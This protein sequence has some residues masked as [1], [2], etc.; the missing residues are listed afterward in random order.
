MPGVE[1]IYDRH[2]YGPEKADA[3]NRLAAE[4]GKIINPP[5][6]NVVAL[7]VV[8]KK[9]APRNEGPKVFRVLLPPGEQ[10]RRPLLR[11]HPEPPRCGHRVEQ[12]TPPLSQLAAS[13]SQRLREIRSVPALAFATLGN[14]MQHRWVDFMV[15][16]LLGLVA[17][18]VVCA[19]FLHIPSRTS[20][21]AAPPIGATA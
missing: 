7:L 5:S 20:S 16:H 11:Q 1:G 14:A 9:K 12:H 21:A 6:D 15:S 4:I 3:L 18:I 17:A 13:P 2:A 8:G 19:L 10:L